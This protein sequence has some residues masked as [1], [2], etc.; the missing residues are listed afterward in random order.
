MP[1]AVAHSEPPR[2][3]VYKRPIE[4]VGDATAQ[5]LGRVVPSIAVATLVTLLLGSKPLLNWA[6]QL[7]ISETSDFVLFVADRWNDTCDRVGV[8]AFADKARALLRYVEA[9]RWGA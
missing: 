1:P 8:T 6:N 7:P 3:I 9:L 2:P 4:V 5:S